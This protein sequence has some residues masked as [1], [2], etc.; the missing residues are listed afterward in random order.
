MITASLAAVQAGA[1]G[2]EA[3]LLVNDVPSGVVETMSG[4]PFQV[5]FTISDMT[6]KYAVRARSTVT[7]GVPSGWQV[8]AQAIEPLAQPQLE[9]LDFTNGQLTATLAQDVAGASSYNAQLIEDGSPVGSVVAMQP[10]AQ[11][12]GKR[13]AQ[14]TV[15][16]D[17]TALNYQ[18]RVQVLG[19]NALPSAWA[20]SADRITHLPEPGIGSP[21]LHIG[22]M[23]INI[24]TTVPGG[25]ELPGTS[26]DRWRAAGDQC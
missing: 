12:P 9:G 21:T 6:A 8:S 14:F 3:Q 25:G 26:G 17:T 23:L 4:T 13:S 16:L 19:L 1:D 15:S 22:G 20:I 18:V 10:T 7:Q 11:Q 2:Y 24:Q 5:Q